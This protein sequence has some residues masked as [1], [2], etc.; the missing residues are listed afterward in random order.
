MAGRG[1]AQRSSIER[2][3]ETQKLL[4]LIPISDGVRRSAVCKLCEARAG[5][6]I[7]R[8]I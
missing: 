3:S 8:T 2:L 6:T 4:N 1:R 7:C 5:N